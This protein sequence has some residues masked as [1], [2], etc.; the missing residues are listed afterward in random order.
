MSL[1]TICNSGWVKSGERRAAK[2]TF[3]AHFFDKIDHIDKA[4]LLGLLYADGWVTYNPG[5]CGGFR[6]GLASTDYELPDMIK[7]LLKAT[8]PIRSFYPK[9]GKQLHEI[10]ISSEQIVSS[11]ISYG[12]VENKSKI[13][14]FP[15]FLD[16]EL[17]PHFIRGYFDGDGGVMIRKN[18]SPQ[19][20]V[21]FCGTFDMMSNIQQV[22]YAVTEKSPKLIPNG[23][24]FKIEYGGNIS[25]TRI[26]NYLYSDNGLYLSRKRFVFDQSNLL[27]N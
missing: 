19:L 21:M 10:I 4:Y 18:P 25:A 13:L 8:N 22:L 6:L 26:Y 2:H 20:K 3:D 24:I 9:R 23:T 14:T 12:V 1:S 7:T 17:T 27:K 5:S 16:S 11:L 15:Q